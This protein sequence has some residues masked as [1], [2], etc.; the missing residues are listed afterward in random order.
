M[1]LESSEKM[2]GSLIRV[3]T[4]ERILVKSHNSLSPNDENNKMILTVKMTR[5]KNN[6]S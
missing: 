5:T 4:T 6:R 3:Q 2:E 1:L